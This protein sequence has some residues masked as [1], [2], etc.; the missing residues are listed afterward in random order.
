MAG[1]RA[2][3]DEAALSLCDADALGEVDVIGIG[4]CFRKPDQSF[5]DRAK[6]SALHG[7]SVPADCGVCI[8]L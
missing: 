4:W 2:R 7:P 5:Q 8:L 3:D 1:T 6:Q